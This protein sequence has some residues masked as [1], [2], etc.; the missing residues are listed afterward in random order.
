[1][2]ASPAAIFILPSRLA[3]SEALLRKDELRGPMAAATCLGMPCFKRGQIGHRSMARTLLFGGNLMCIGL[4]LIAV[5]LDTPALAS[6]L[7]QLR[8]HQPPLQLQC[9]VTLVV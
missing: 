8:F 2:N 6:G 1:M 4:G 7:L 9:I 5:G 3:N